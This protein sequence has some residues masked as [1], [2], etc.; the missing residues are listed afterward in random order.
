MD[1]SS[2]KTCPKCKINPRL[3][4]PYCKQCWREYQAARRQRP[5]IKTAL[6]EKRKA[7]YQSNPEY[8][9]EISRRYRARHPDRVIE[10]RKHNYDAEKS[11]QRWRTYYEK[12]SEQVKQK[13]AE[14]RRR[15]PEKRRIYQ[16]KRTHRLRS[17]EFTLSLDQIAFI[18]NQ[19]CEFC[20]VTESITLAHKMPVSKG[21]A[22]TMENVFSLCAPCNS[23]MHTKTY[24]EVLLLIEQGKWEKQ[25]NK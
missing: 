25:V 23:R 14:H 17:A 24:D 21:G 6:D 10:S 15:N 2:P 12:K 20:G 9:R 1:Q 18:R 3:S 16:A 11:G 5:E 7:A 19:P 22:T 8:F 13:S 4:T